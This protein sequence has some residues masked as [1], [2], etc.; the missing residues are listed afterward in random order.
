MFGADEAALEG[1]ELA[2]EGGDGD[3]GQAMLF[4]V[5]DGEGEGGGERSVGGLKVRESV[6]A[7]V[8]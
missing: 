4:G 2:L 8:N 1:E 5:G 3:V 7:G 6:L